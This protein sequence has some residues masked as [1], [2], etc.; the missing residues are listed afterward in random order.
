MK[1]LPD[2][3]L[4]MVDCDWWEDIDI[5]YEELAVLVDLFEILSSI[6]KLLII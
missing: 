4:V 2:E 5:L 6:L 3:I 1:I